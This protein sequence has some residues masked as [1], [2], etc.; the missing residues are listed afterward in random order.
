M[1]N[2]KYE[3][4]RQS[5]FGQIFNSL[6]LLALVGMSLFVP[7]WMGLAGGGKTALEFK[8]KTWEAMGQ[9]PV[10]SAAYEKLGLTPET[11]HDMIAARF[12]YSFSVPEL[13]ATALVIVVYFAFVF[14]FSEKEYRDVI[15]ERFGDK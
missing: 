15:R 8:D 6:F 13:I 5:A 12:D 3:P 4:P 10:T 9:T 14:R 1:V 7:L 11:A 2:G